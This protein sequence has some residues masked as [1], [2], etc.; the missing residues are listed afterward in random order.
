M[1]LGGPVGGSA[2]SAA[3][4]SSKVQCSNAA[5]SVPYTVHAS[6]IY[7][8]AS[9]MRGP[10]NVHSVCRKRRQTGH[11]SSASCGHRRQC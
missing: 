5:G 9:R 8:T 11:V 2:V 1:D 3:S 10:S 4:C 7:A 6:C